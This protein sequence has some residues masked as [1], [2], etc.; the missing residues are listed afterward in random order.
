MAS[1]R[2]SSLH[3]CTAGGEPLTAPRE[4]ES[5]LITLDQPPDQLTQVRLLRHGEPLRL[6]TQ[7][8]GGEV[9]LIAEWPRSGTGRYRLALDQDGDTEVLD[10]TVTPRKISTEAYAQLV[11]DLQTRLPASVAISLQRLGAL[12]G[13]ELR[14]PGETTLAQ[15]LAR[16]RIAVRGSEETSGLVATLE[17]IARD[18]H[19]IL[20]KREE[21]VDRERV[22]RLEPAGLLA[23]IRQPNNLDP[24]LGLPKRA[25]DV[26]VEESVDVYENRL[27]SSFHDEVAARL[28]RLAAALSASGAFAGLVEVEDL[29]FQLQRSRRVAGFLDQVGRLEQLP[30]RVTMVLLKRREYRSMLKDYLRFRRSA[31]VQLDEPALETPLES[32]PALYELWGTLLVIETLLEVAAD[33]GYDIKNQQLAKPIN[34]G[35]Y[36]KVLPDGDPAVEL[37]HPDTDS[38]VALFPQRSYKSS[39]TDGLRSISFKQIPDVSVDIRHGDRRALLLFDPKYKLQSE[40]E[41]EPGDGKPKKIDIDTM[42][43][44]RDA[45]RTNTEERIVTYAAILYPGPEERYGDGIEALSSRPLDPRTLQARVREVFRNA[46]DPSARAAADTFF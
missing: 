30:T 22:R 5:C 20:Q 38:T 28:R 35:I 16:L 45:I 46:L 21:W 23:A 41:A 33:A 36:L 4:W 26:R 42:H 32:L 2:T 11:D 44:Y 39:L 19:R 31:F 25:P 37:R 43:A 13:I 7:E 6:L 27:L 18:P 29:L 1:P 14:P 40:E 12:S 17:A 34:G 3:F 8:L 24:G 10:V 15:E 9:R